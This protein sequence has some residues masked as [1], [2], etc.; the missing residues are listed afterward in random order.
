VI[1]VDDQNKVVVTEQLEKVL[2]I[3]RRPTPGI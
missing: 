3:Q 1:W 2:K